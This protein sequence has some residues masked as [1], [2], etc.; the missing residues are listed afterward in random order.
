MSKLKILE[1]HLDGI[2]QEMQTKRTRK[3]INEECKR[4]KKSCSRDNFNN[5]SFCEIIIQGDIGSVNT[6]Y[7]ELDT[8][9]L[10]GC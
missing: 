2:C 5:K 1:L 8:L 6:F 7:S 9:N 4:Q 10:K 3:F